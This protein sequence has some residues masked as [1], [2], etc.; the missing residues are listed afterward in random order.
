MKFIVTEPSEVVVEIMQG[1]VDVQVNR[2]NI[3]PFNINF[4]KPERRTT[5]KQ[6]RARGNGNNAASAGPLRRHIMFPIGGRRTNDVADHKERRIGQIKPQPV[7][8]ESAQAYLPWLN[9]RRRKSDDRRSTNHFCHYV[10][11]PDPRIRALER[12]KS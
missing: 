9:P 4:V 2:L 12:R 8:C 1:G 10:S 5:T 3:P 7:W 11:S 6:R